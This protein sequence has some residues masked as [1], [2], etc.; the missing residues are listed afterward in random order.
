MPLQRNGPLPKQVQPTWLLEGVHELPRL[1]ARS[2][3][4]VITQA[5]P[6][7]P[8]LHPQ[9]LPTGAGPVQ[10][11][12]DEGDLLYFH[13]ASP[14]HFGGTAAGDAL[15]RRAEQV[16]AQLQESI[17]LNESGIPFRAILA[18]WAAGI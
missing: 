18:D 9:S 14:D 16:V 3:L 8:Q 10:P 11:H 12:F 1:S 4:C 6:L 13:Q 7:P 15:Q 17:K 5:H 2:N